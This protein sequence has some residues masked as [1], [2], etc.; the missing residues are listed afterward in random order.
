M[1]PHYAVFFLLLVGWVKDVPCQDNPFDVAEKCGYM[2]RFD[3][4]RN[5][6]FAVHMQHVWLDLAINDANAFLEGV[7]TLAFLPVQAAP[8]MR[9]DFHESLT[10]W[11]VTTAS[12]SPL[13]FTHAQQQLRIVRPLV[14]QKADTLIIHYSG[15]PSFENMYYSRSVHA[16]GNIV[17]TRSQPYGCSYWWPCQNTLTDKID[18]LDIKLTCRQGLKGVANGLLKET[19]GVDSQ[20][21]YFLWQHRY[22]IVPYLVAISVSPY[23]VL[24]EYAKVQGGKDSIKMVHYVYPFYE[25]TARQLVRQTAPI[26]RLFDSLFGP[27]PFAKEHY[28]HA[29]FHQ[30]GGMEHQTMSFMGSFSFDLIAHELAHQWFGN[31]ITCAEWPELWLNEGFATY[32]NMLCYRFLRSDSLWRLQLRNTIDDVCSTPNGSVFVRDTTRFQ[33]LFNQRMVY[34]KAAMVLHMLR[35]TCGE[36][37]FFEGVKNYL[38]DTLLSYSFAR[39]RDLQWHLEMASGKS[40]D[41]FFDEWIMGEGFPFYH[42]RF[43]AKPMV[44]DLFIDQSPSHPSVEFFSNPIPLRLIGSGG[45]T[46]DVQ[47][48]PD[49]KQFNTRLQPGFHVQEVL[50]DPDMHLLARGL[51]FNE[52]EKPSGL[53]LFPNPS[54]NL[55]FV[56]SNTSD[57][58]EIRVIDHVGKV[59][60]KEIPAPPVKKGNAY[61]INV[62]SFSQGLY[63]FEVTTLKGLFRTKWIKK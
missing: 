37:A 49:S 44:C 61:A 15:Q 39:Q 17:A 3:V 7:C 47:L 24:E 22:P 32:A 56:Q 36:P 26:M 51:V 35:F 9:L 21:H 5:M 63:T 19:G 54:D 45:D 42:I 23:T 33:T 62:T 16:D 48:I 8:V 27:Y 43:D 30:G 55:L 58:V 18:S 60:Y 52:S 28:G 34:K 12:G 38:E 59:L 20:H 46:V 14:P 31:K 53:L 50:F 40:L 57:I 41:R 2:E 25:Q 13:A 11:S 29:Q 6:D 1:R 10:V 4:R